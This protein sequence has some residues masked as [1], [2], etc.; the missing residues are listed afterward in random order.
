MHST[1]SEIVKSMAGN[2][3][4]G[5]N[6]ENLK[7]IKEVPGLSREANRHK[8]MGLK[9]ST[10]EDDASKLKREPPTTPAASRL[11]LSDL[12]GM[13]DVKS[14]EKK[15]TP[16]ERILW[17]HDASSMHGSDSSYGA[18]R[19][20]KKRARSSSPTSSPVQA[21]VQ[22]TNKGEA[23]DL[24]RLN[25]CL[26]TPQMDPSTDLWDRYN[27]STN[28]G[29]PTTPQLPALAH[30][31]YA[32]SPQSSKEGVPKI[33]EALRK[34]IVRSNTCG[35]DWPKRRKVAVFEQQQG[36][37]VFMESFN[38]GT[39][40]LSRVSVLLDKVQEG[41]TSREGLQ[42]SPGAS[43]SSPI[44]LGRVSKTLEASS[45]L[46]HFD[47]R[48]TTFITK[49]SETLINA[50]HTPEKPIIPPEQFGI[51]L[52]SNSSDYGEF[53]EDGFEE[54]ML[55]DV[56]TTGVPLPGS[57]ATKTVKHL[58]AQVQEPANSELI[59]TEEHDEFGEL[60]GDVCAADLE[61]IVAK[62]DA[63]SPGIVLDGAS[64]T[65]N[66]IEE[67]KGL[68]ARKNLKTDSDEEYGDEIDEVDFAA[69]EAA[70]TQSLQQS[71]S[72]MPTV[73]IEIL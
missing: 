72:S 23:F 35:T 24:Q 25:K 12:V 54:S 11:A 1:G 36:D 22:S 27:L 55:D 4:E 3:A 41:Y 46:R 32:S 38:S 63:K 51:P 68:T 14:E 30:I 52:D 45:P 56:D 48:A 34:S 31:M 71:A 29:T 33:E 37:D 61:D 42:I 10:Q 8:R 19:R 49:Q 69:A 44:L 43:S 58:P 47:S 15:I 66:L 26:K 16:D 65:G 59:L 50:L 5:E 7:T 62:Y 73:C 6:K 13:K 53:D 28:K 57:S 21:S 40:K 39:S 17:R 60:D 9:S 70:A 20:I 2:L 18:L 67:Q 64:R